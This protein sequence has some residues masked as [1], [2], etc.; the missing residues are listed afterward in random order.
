MTDVTARDRFLQSL[1]LARG[2]AD[3]VGTRD[4]E[5][6]RALLDFGSETDGNTECVERVGLAVL[7]QLHG[8]GPAGFALRHSRI[9]VAD[10]L[11]AAEGA[12]VPDQVTAEFPDV[13]QEDWDAVLQLAT[14]ILVAFQAP[15]SP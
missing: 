14:L 1:V 4:R 15:P 12:P 13:T 3:Q 8:S 9:A 6:V 11:N 5:F 2:D 7:P 10:V